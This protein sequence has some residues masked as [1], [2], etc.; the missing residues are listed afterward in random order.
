MISEELKKAIFNELV[1]Q[2]GKAFLQE[3]DIKFLT[4]VADEI[5]VQRERYEKAVTEEE[6]QKIKTNLEHLQTQIMLQVESRKIKLA[7]KGEEILNNGIRLVIQKFI[8]FV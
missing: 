8:P 3:P 2:I 1:N 7:R 6:R 5:A 4:E